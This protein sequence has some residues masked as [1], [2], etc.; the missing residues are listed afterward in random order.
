[1][2]DNIEEII[3]SENKSR[4]KWGFI[5]AFTCAVLWGLG[6]VAI[7]MLWIVPPI[8]DFSIFPDGSAGFLVATICITTAMA[9]AFSIVLAI[10][11]SGSLG[12]LADI[13]RTLR[14]YKISKWY[15]FAAAFGGPIAIF[16]STLAVGY[17]GAAFSASAA[18]LCSVVGAF[19]AKVWYSENITRRVWIGI[20]LIL[21]GG[22]FIWNP[23]QMMAEIMNPA[24][25]DGVWLGYLG[26]IMSAIGWGLEGAIAARVLDMTDADTGLVVRFISEALIWSLILVPVSMFLFG[27]DVMTTAL[28]GTFTSPSFLIWLTIAALSLGVCYIAL[29]KAYPLIGV[30]RGLSIGTLY[31]VFAILSLSI[32]MGVPIGWGIIVGASIAVIG[33]FVMYWDSGCDSAME[34]TRDCAPAVE[35]IG[36]VD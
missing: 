35:G 28:V 10:V 19:A 29:Y 16:G 5:W 17:I 20:G 14:A 12:K 4:V 31:V 23:S 3:R 13:P 8:G 9:I 21:F 33:T 30:G 34:C 27:F 25:P 11:W 2:V 36:R 26:G 22:I 18:L 7:S 1:M 15:V 24:S 6:Y 32:F